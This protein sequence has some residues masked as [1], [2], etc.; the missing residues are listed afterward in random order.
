MGNRPIP[1]EVMDDWPRPALTQPAI[2]L[3][4]FAA[5]HGELQAA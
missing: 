2:R 5:P 4:R 3:A 1:D